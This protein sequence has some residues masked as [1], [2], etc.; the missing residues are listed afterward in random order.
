MQ[1]SIS[2]R[3]FTAI[4]SITLRSLRLKLLQEFSAARRKLLHRAI[5]V[6]N[7]V[8]IFGR[9]QLYDFT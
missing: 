6:E 2:L 4:W 1:L 8:E 5:L 7:L 3:T 9:S